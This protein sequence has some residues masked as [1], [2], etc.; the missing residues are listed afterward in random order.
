MSRPGIAYEYRIAIADQITELEH[1]L[2]RGDAK[3]FDDYLAAVAEVRAMRS[4]LRLFE[5]VLDKYQDTEEL[6]DL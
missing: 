6:D 1:K 2:G 3:S 5:S 4:A